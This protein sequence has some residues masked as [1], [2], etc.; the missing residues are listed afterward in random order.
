[1]RKGI[2]AI[3]KLRTFNSLSGSSMPRALQPPRPPR[4]SCV[5]VSYHGGR[6]FF[7]YLLSP[8]T[9]DGLVYIDGKMLP[10]PF[11]SDLRPGR[12]MARAVMA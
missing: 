1:M 7:S 9:F 5:L 12:D 4:R 11:S 8:F 2:P 6:I 10:P 3:T